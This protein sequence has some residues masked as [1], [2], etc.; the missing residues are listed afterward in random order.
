MS[1]KTLQI[2]SL[3]S[4]LGRLNFLPTMV[5]FYL[6]SVNTVCSFGQWSVRLQYV[7]GYTRSNTSFL[8][9]RRS[10]NVW[11]FKCMW[12]YTY[13]WFRSRIVFYFK[14]CSQWLCFLLNLP[15]NNP[16]RL[17]VSVPEWDSFLAVCIKT[18]SHCLGSTVLKQVHLFS[19]SCLNRAV[20]NWPWNV[21]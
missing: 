15:P 6:P 2:L 11:R 4:F 17:L 19:I 16:G 13:F 18:Q 14:V 3:L 1:Y 12:L 9:P 7:W 10:E 20:E 8:R 5:T 21:K